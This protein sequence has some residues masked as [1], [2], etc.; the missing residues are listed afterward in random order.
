MEE[1][2]SLGCHSETHAKLVM[3]LFEAASCFCLTREEAILTP[4]CCS[5]WLPVSCLWFIFLISDD[6]AAAIYRRVA[7]RSW[8]NNR[9]SSFVAGR[10]ILVSCIFMCFSINFQTNSCGF[11]VCLFFS[12]KIAF[13][14]IR[15]RIKTIFFKRYSILRQKKIRFELTRTLTIYGDHGIMAHIPWWLSQ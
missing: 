1:N 10:G 9:L 2:Y 8:R 6:Q 11:F 12:Y 5:E 7:L 13:S 3:K 4:D 15:V 14:S